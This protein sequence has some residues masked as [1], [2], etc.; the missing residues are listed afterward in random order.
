MFRK[1]RTILRL[2]WLIGIRRWDGERAI[3]KVRD[4]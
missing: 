2:F 1:L 3:A 4:E